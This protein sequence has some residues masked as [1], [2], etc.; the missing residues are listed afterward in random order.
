MA[1]RVSVTSPLYG[2]SNS[3]N[4]GGRSTTL[5][6]QKPPIAPRRRVNSGNR[7][8][9]TSSSDYGS[10]NK[11]GLTTTDRYA[12]KGVASKGR[13]TYGGRGL[14]GNGRSSPGIAANGS[15]VPRPLPKGPGPLDEYGNKI[16]VREGVRRARD[17]FERGSIASNGS[18]THTTYTRHTPSPIGSYPVGSTLS[19][20][21]RAGS[22]SDL[23]TRAGNLNLA[24]GNSSSLLSSSRHFSSH[25]NLTES[26]RPLNRGAVDSDAT[27]NRYNASDYVDHTSP[28]HVSSYKSSCLSPPALPPIVARHST[29]R[30]HHE[31][32][33]GAASPRTN[34]NN[35]RSSVSEPRYNTSPPKQ[36]RVCMFV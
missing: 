30:K 29:E 10:Y 18:T 6:A 24:G 7:N 31:E 8:F 5:Q 17:T 22:I 25:H 15:Y 16:A 1:T 20:A 19:R 11:S 2:G 36:N 26:V 35:S 34:G 32:D 23:S 3:F 9:S 27:K 33:S 4:R 14:N 28:R 21:K 12:L 13:T